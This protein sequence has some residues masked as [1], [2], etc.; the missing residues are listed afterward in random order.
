MLPP[1]AAGSQHNGTQ[2]SV[3]CP[4]CPGRAQPLSWQALTRGALQAAIAL[5]TIVVRTSILDATQVWVSCALLLLL[6]LLLLGC[7][8]AGRGVGKQ[9]LLIHVCA[10][11]SGAQH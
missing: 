1:R 7:S 10:G 6:L 3:S 11:V 5:L 9:A 8:V 4:V 2:I